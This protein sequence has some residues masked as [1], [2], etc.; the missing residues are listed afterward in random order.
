M[1]HVDATEFE[2]FER[3]FARLPSQMKAKAFAR[4]M[5]RINTMVRTRV[6]RRSSERIKLPQKH[7]R[8][9]YTMLNTGSDTLEHVVRS[10]WIPLIKLGARRSPKGITVPRRGSIRGA[11]IATMKSGHEGAFMRKTSKRTPIQELYGP[12]PASD[13]GNHPD[14]FAQVLADVAE[15]HLVPRILH[16]VERLLPD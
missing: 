9:T 8:P 6:M 12:N 2:R 1:I 5:R 13:I 7:I 3:E 15:T 11:F 4:A 16:E 14:V 10:G